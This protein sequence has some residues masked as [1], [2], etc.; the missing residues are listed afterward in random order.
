MNKCV[1]CLNA[2]SASYVLYIS[3]IHV[4]TIDVGYDSLHKDTYLLTHSYEHTET[5]TGKPKSL[6]DMQTLKGLQYVCL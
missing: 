3:H 1:K 6:T 5:L 2:N 4:L